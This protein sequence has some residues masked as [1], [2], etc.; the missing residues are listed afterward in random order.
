MIKQMTVGDLNQ[1]LKELHFDQ[2]EEDVPI[3][4]NVERYEVGL[5]AV[6]VSRNSADKVISLDLWDY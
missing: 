5:A 2:L 6:S 3:L 4:L 1:R